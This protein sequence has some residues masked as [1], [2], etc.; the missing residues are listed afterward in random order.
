MLRRRRAHRFLPSEVWFLILERLEL[1][2]INEIRLVNSELRD[3]A[4]PLRFRALSFTFSHSSIRN[5][6][7]IASK[8][9]LR[10]HVRRLDAREVL[11]PHHFCGYDTWEQS[12]SLPGDPQREN[13]VY[14]SDNDEVLMPYEQWSRLSDGEKEALFCAYEEYRVAMED[15]FRRQGIT[16]G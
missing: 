3:Y 1:R 14:P 8:D 7:Q 4:T 10:R 11:L 13:D 2:D 6:R 15:E 5:L 12:V 9:N 16:H